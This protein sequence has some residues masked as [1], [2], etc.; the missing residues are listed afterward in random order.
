[1]HMF[2]FCISNYRPHCS[3]NSLLQ[4]FS[5]DYHYLY[6][7]IWMLLPINTWNEKKD[8]QGSSRSLV[9]QYLYN[10]YLELSSNSRLLDCCCQLDLLNYYFPLAKGTE[11]RK[12][13]CKGFGR[14]LA[15]YH[16]MRI[17]RARCTVYFNEANIEEGVQ[18][19]NI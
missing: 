2:Y 12:S 16:C 19:N 7:Y 6:K 3:F 17:K 10:C 11:C 18:N 1:M 14:S 5:E 15:I 13:I 4:W 9:C 8:T